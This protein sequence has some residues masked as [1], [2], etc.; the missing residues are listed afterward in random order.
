MRTDRRFGYGDV[1][2][3]SEGKSLSEMADIKERTYAMG[4]MHACPIVPEVVKY[5]AGGQDEMVGW[6]K[7]LKRYI[8]C[9]YVFSEVILKRALESNKHLAQLLT[10]P[11]PR[12]PGEKASDKIDRSLVSESFDKEMA[13]LSTLWGYALPRIFLLGGRDDSGI[14]IREKMTRMK[15]TLDRL[16]PR[17]VDPMMLALELSEEVYKQGASPEDIFGHLLPSGLLEEEGSRAMYLEA[18]TRM[19]VH[20]PELKEAYLQMLVVNGPVEMHK[21]GIAVPEDVI[22][23]K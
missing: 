12:M 19:S 20:A 3:H 13:P 18:I 23:T 8:E 6:K 10:T 16:I 17:A 22:V 11:V 1:W 2:T 14:G 9:N 5:Y 21:M 7:T 4:Y 15:E